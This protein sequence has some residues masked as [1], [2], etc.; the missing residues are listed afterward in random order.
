MVNSQKGDVEA[1][2]GLQNEVDETTFPGDVTSGGKFGP[3]YQAAPDRHLLNTSLTDAIDLDGDQ[4][5][6]SRPTST[7]APNQEQNLKV[8][9]E[10]QLSPVSYESAFEGTLDDVVLELARRSEESDSPDESLSSNVTQTTDGRDLGDGEE[11]RN[12][13]TIEDTNDSKNERKHSDRSESDVGS[14]ESNSMPHNTPELGQTDTLTST[15]ETAVTEES[16]QE[17]EET[18]PDTGEIPIVKI[19]P[20]PDTDGHDETGA[21]T[22]PLEKTANAQTLPKELFPKGSNSEPDYEE[23]AGWSDEDAPG[24]PQDV[25][26]RGNTDGVRAPPNGD[27]VPTSFVMVDNQS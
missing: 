13:E 12:A 2:D 5:D 1:H 6:G 21:K 15:E 25:I 24:S 27:S 9:F 23:F 14:T 3:T 18:L 10:R 22:P 26:F 17:A 8:A 19:T 11:D 20:V 7:H 4:S 16:E